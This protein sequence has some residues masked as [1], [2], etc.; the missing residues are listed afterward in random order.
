M[1]EFYRRISYTSSNDLLENIQELFGFVGMDPVTST[2]HF[3]EI[4]LGHLGVTR[5][6]PAVVQ[7]IVV[8]GELSVD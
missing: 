4:V 1:I 2:F 3:V 8:V 6:V 5:T 7:V